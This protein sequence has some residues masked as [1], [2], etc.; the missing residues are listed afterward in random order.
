[1][2]LHP[3][4]GDNFPGRRWSEAGFAAV[5]R[6]ASAAGHHVVV[7]GSAA[8]RP[9]AARVA[10][11]VGPRAVDAAGRL[12]LDGLVALVAGARALVSNDTGPVHLASALGVPTLAIFG[13]NTPA[14]YGPLA[15]GSRAFYRAL[16][17]S[18]CITAANY[19]S[20]RCRIFA[21]MAAIPTGEVVAG[22]QHLL[23]LQALN[24]GPRFCTTS[25]DPLQ[26]SCAGPQVDHR[27]RRAGWG[28]E[29][30]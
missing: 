16:P 6:A 15:P 24:K 14:I 12:A 28:A 20:S 11:A 22:L 3:G 19:R 17:C 10:A 13:P 27:D 5:G 8:E 29:D 2:L 1:V 7:T 21:C 23:G 18:P 9:L 25:V 30:P 26:V 4:S